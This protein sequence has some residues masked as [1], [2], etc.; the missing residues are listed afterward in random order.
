MRINCLLHGSHP[1]L[2]PEVVRS[3]Q[4]E[5][6]VRVAVIQGQDQVDQRLP[7]A[8]VMPNSTVRLI[9]ELEMC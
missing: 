5:V 2:L 3:Q 1:G 6:I 9:K 8:L 4:A 7:A